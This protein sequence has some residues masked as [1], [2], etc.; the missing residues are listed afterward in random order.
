M[1]RIL[2]EIGLGFLG[3]LHLIMEGVYDF[4]QGVYT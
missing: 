4:D 1:A 2:L 3:K